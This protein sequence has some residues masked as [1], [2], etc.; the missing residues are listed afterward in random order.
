M[1]FNSLGYAVFLPVVLAGYF[2]LPH[3]ARIF[4]L[5]AASCLFYMVYRP[6]YILVLASL[7]AIDYGAAR[8]I[9]GAPRIK[10]RIYLWTSIAATCSVLFFFKYFNF[11]SGTV[12]AGASLL[13]L[14]LTPR[15]LSYALPIGLSFHTFQSLAY[16]IE[17]YRGNQPAE[18]NV[19]VYATYVMFFPQL[20]AGPIERPSHLLRQ[21]REVHTFDVQQAGEGLKRIAWG[22]FK[23]A[24]I[25][26][27]LAVI[28]KV[29]FAKPDAVNG[30]CLTLAAVAFTYQIYCDFSGYSD[31]AVGSAQLLGFRLMENFD[32]PFCARSI[33]E[34][35]R[36]WHI[37]LSTWFRDYVYIPLG[38]SRGS[39]LFTARN[40]MLTFLL[41]G[42]W[43]G[44]SWNFLV[45][46]GLNGAWLIAGRASAPLRHRVAAE[47][48]LGEN[49]PLRVAAGIVTTFS[50][51]CVGF[52]IFRATDLP[53]ASYI[54]TH[55]FRNFEVRHLWEFGLD[56]FQLKLAI[57]AV[58][59]LELVQWIQRH[60]PRIT[61]ADSA[62]PVLRWVSYLALVSAVL[63]LGVYLDANA[64]IYFQF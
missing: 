57:V 14:R 25:A 17:V 35:W 39:G 10:A 29:V 8:C 16:V 49:H 22:L 27:R 31:I 2:A 32:S 42:L 48:G 44:A 19:F 43:H 28:V 56:E 38:G 9:E 3:R 34:F 55:L 51:V 13:G 11:F 6:A 40:L 63:L 18:R 20:V 4:F 36:R 53:Q 45:W 15:V 64:F 12:S 59:F 30:F 41:S 58:F 50:F 62:P 33:G 52:V 24:V 61:L 26:D 37:S 23:K 21:F 5:L 7:I 54:L 47:F 46:G 1:L 60:P